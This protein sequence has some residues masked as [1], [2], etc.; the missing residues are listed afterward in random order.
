MRCHRL[1]ASGGTLLWVSRF[2]EGGSN[3][4]QL[5]AV[6][7]VQAIMW[8]GGQCRMYEGVAYEAAFTHV[9]STLE[10]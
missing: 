10:P 1:W 4:W 2:S 3:L 5:G 8:H 6:G 7:H 9:P